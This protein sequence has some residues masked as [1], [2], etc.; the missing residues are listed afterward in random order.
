M[1]GSTWLRARCALSGH[2]TKMGM[3]VAA[4]RA[5]DY[6]VEGGSGWEAGDSLG[7]LLSREVMP[8]G[9]WWR[10]DVE[11]RQTGQMGRTRTISNGQDL[12]ERKRWKL[13]MAPGEAYDVIRS[14]D[15]RGAQQA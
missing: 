14:P 6:P 8:S 11:E 10:L 15:C 3:D 1:P 2:R 12:G 9:Q 4:E 7:L 5:C 13:K